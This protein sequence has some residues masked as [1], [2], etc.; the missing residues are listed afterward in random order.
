VAHAGASAYHGVRRAQERH[1]R[2][3]QRASERQ[4]RHEQAAERR[5]LEREQQAKERRQARADARFAARFL[6]VRHEGP[7]HSHPHVHALF[8]TDHRGLNTRDLDRMRAALGEREALREREQAQ[9]RQWQQQAHQEYEH[10]R[11]HAAA[12]EMGR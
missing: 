2:A 9:T 4:A 11:A 1:A 3:A 12:Q 8:V 10:G 6:Y 7:G 5:R